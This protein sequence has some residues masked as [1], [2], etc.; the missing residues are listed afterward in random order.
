MQQ[1]I[2]TWFMHA[3]AEVYFFDGASHVLD[4]F[5]C[6][7][8]PL[9]LCSFIFYFQLDLTM[10]IPK[11]LSTAA[12]LI[13]APSFAFGWN[14]CLDQGPWGDTTLYFDKLI[15]CGNFRYIMKGKFIAYNHN[16]F[17]C[18][19]YPRKWIFNLMFM[20]VHLIDFK[21]AW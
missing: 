20:H 21:T 8:N 13:W 16:E 12:I 1:F 15:P 19:I 11:Y 18:F 5:Q 2:C 6:L 10:Q 14:I 17:R 7:T 9:P 4:C 3:S